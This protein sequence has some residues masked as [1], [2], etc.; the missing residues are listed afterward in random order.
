M[1]LDELLKSYSKQHWELMARI[2]LVE[3]LKAE[4]EGL[5]S[6]VDFYKSVFIEQVTINSKLIKLN[7]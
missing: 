4:I 7:K 3:E 1:E 6:E 2:V 5:E